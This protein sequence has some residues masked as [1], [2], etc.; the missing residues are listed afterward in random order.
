[1]C[2][3]GRT[4]SPEVVRWMLGDVRY[5]SI[6]ECLLDVRFTPETLLLTASHIASAS[7]ASFF[8]RLT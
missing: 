2:A 4:G 8:C 6:S 5:G 1:V 3:S 7:V